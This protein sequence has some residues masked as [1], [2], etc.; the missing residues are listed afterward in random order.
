MLFRSKP[1]ELILLPAAKSEFLTT[2]QEYDQL[3]VLYVCE[4]ILESLN[5][6]QGLQ[7]VMAKIKDTRDALTALTQTR[8]Q[9]EKRKL[10]DRRILSNSESRSVQ[11]LILDVYD[12]LPISID[13]DQRWS[14]SAILRTMNTVLVEKITP[15]LISQETN[16]LVHREIFTLSNYPLR[17][18]PLP[19][20]ALGRILRDVKY[21]PATGTTAE[22]EINCLMISLEEKDKYAKD[23]AFYNSIVPYV[24][25][26]NDYLKFIG[27]STTGSIVM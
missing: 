26:E 23:P 24:Y 21:L 6:T 3:L 11:S 17:Y 8:I 9:S 4:R 19:K 18:I 12:R 20:R 25:V 7:V 2:P 1:Y 16:Y 5:D 13:E 10:Q 15:E 27:G 22:D 14:T